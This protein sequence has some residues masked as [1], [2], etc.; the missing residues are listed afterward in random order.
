MKRVD[1]TSILIAVVALAGV[2]S[3]CLIPISI[4]A[5]SAQTVPG[6]RNM[7]NGLRGGQPQVAS[8]PARTPVSP[9]DSL[10]ALGRLNESINTLLAEQ[11]KNFVKSK[12][13]FGLAV[14]SLTKQRDVFALNPTIALTP[15]STT[16]LFSTFGALDKF[17]TKHLV[18]TSIFTEAT[19]IRDG[20][21]DGNVYLVGHGDPLLDVAD[22]E[23]LAM[24]LH[25]SGV[26][27]ITGG[28]YGDDSF[29]DHVTN[30]QEY[31]GDDDEV[32]PTAPI[33]ALSV[34]RNLI[35]VIVS[36]GPTPKK[37]VHVQTFPSCD[38]FSFTIDATV[39]ASV[40]PVKS[41]R[42][43][44][45][46]AAPKPVLSISEAYGQKN[47]KQHFVVRGSI[48]PN[49]T[50][51]KLFF[52]ENPAPVT[53]S[54]L[55]KRIESMGI[56]IGGATGIRRTPAAVSEMASIQ[57]S[58]VDIITIINKKSDNFAAEHLFKMLGGGVLDNSMPE[59]SSKDNH[60]MQASVEQIQGALREY[61]IVTSTGSVSINDGS[62]LSRRN[63]A[64]PAVMVRLLDRVR[65]TP[66]GNEFLNSLSIAGLDGTLQYRMRSSGAE[67]NVRAKT[68]TLKN[69]SAL[70]GYVQ[71]LDGERLV[72]SFMFNGN[73]VWLY[74]GLENR[75][76]E[77][78]AN[79]SYFTPVRVQDSAAVN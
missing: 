51:S 33:S 57:R 55:R 30:R 25:A 9:Q 52:I 75:L 32:Q 66:F 59:M 78:L 28:V 70:A 24:Q 26:R 56:T 53:A 58:I 2:V 35:T 67:Y 11:S 5:Q 17:G 7:Q 4:S 14:Y 47:G 72:F 46:K 10:A 29:F 71:T 18:A 31:S 65:D 43:R 68:G 36:G 1:R 6:M 49:T 3:C 69:V 12:T 45:A 38:A 73:A 13:Q 60:T 41:K 76:C 74:K 16:K 39:Q 77:L 42:R 27:R 64:T 63:K 61:H 40:K 19:E 20:V 48:A 21:L 15:A 44:A 79:F 22:L 37:P 54:M 62:G 23:R 34:Q 50:I 8:V